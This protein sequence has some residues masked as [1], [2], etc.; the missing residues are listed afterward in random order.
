[1]LAL[2]RPDKRLKTGSKRLQALGPLD[3]DFLEG[4]SSTIKRPSGARREV[5]V[6][7]L[8]RLMV[9]TRAPSVSTTPELIASNNGAGAAS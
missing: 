7:S 5:A 6:I 1:M 3:K 2:L 8:P 9:L 4:V